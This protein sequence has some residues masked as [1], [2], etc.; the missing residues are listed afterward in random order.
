MDRVLSFKWVIGHIPGKA[1]PAADYLS[2]MHE[3]PCAPLHLTVQGH[4]PAYDIIID[5]D[6]DKKEEHA[7][8]TELDREE[9]ISQLNQG[10][11]ANDPAG[12]SDEN[13]V[14]PQAPVANKGTEEHPLN[15]ISIANV[16]Y[17]R[18]NTEPTP[19]T[20]NALAEPNPAD[21]YDFTDKRNVLDMIAEQGRDPEIVQIRRWIDAQLIPDVRYA[22]LNLKKYLRQISRL[23]I[24]NNLLQ[25]R[26]Y[27][28][29]GK[30]ESYQICMPSHLVPE[31]L[32]RLHNSPLQGHRGIRQTIE[33]CRR[34]FYFPSYQETIEEYIKNCSSCLQVKRTAD[35][36]LTPPLQPV[37]ATTSFPGDMLEVDIVGNINRSGNTH[38]CHILAGIDVF[39]QYLFAIPIKRVSAVEIAK[40][41]VQMFLQHA[42]IPRKILTDKGTAFRGRLIVELAKLLN[43]E[44]SHATTKH[45]RT[46]GALERRHANIKKTLKIY[47]GTE[48]RNWHEFVSYAM[49]I[50]NTSYNAKTRCSPSDLFHGHSP[51]RPVDLRFNAISIRRRDVKFGLTREVQDRLLEL[52]ARQHE[53]IISRYLKYKESFDKKACAQPL[54]IH[55]YCMLLN[56]LFDTQQQHMNKMQC[57]WI[58]TFRVEQRLSNENY[59]VRRVNT[60]Y[61][62]LVH[63]IRLRPFT[64]QFKVVDVAE[65]K[66]QDFCL[67]PT[68][69]EHQMEPGL[70]D[71]VRE[72]LANN[73][74][75]VRD[76]PDSSFTPAPSAAAPANVSRT[77]ITYQPAGD[78]ATPTSAAAQPASPGP[79]TRTDSIPPA[80]TRARPS[81]SAR[82]L[83]PVSESAEWTLDPPTGGLV[84]KGWTPPPSPIDPRTAPALPTV[85]RLVPR[86]DP[87]PQATPPATTQGRKPTPS[88]IPVLTKRYLTRSTCVIGTPLS[89]PPTRTRKP[90]TPAVTSNST[91][92]LI[93]PVANG[94]TT[95]PPPTTPAMTSNS[96]RPLIGPVANGQTTRPPPTTPA[97]TSNS[98]R[99]LIDPVANGQTTRPPAHYDA[100]VTSNSTRPLN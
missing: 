94:Q 43:I 31:L 86:A 35:K 92:P 91:R 21:K 77:A 14:P 52:Y 65:V 62:Q 97:V 27:T 48:N 53:D 81:T 47:E 70:L 73:P 79:E 26:Y 22:S 63:R 10:E 49:Y 9:T 16:I 67:D 83:P 28:H 98:T 59:L 23:T 8:I 29:T 93:G 55:S 90:K 19:V 76:M 46:I 58:P 75:G 3:D 71:K 39:S 20:L 95:R 30:I 61:T 72:L 36:N 100:A 87:P 33:E 88:S 60:H 80:P 74:D 4:V 64:P 25:R 24:R 2:R 41:L 82:T 17:S 32:V 40:N 78:T 45:A 38:Y 84:A 99:P 12:T 18:R 51:D 11:T 66:P 50:H 6:T 68:V 37:T 57:K 1:N 44:I 13:T 5:M 54:M 56:P 85:G 42:Y 34:K 89:L 69:P 7:E 96:T 15:V